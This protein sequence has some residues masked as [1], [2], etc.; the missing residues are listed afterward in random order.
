MTAPTSA[1]HV[2]DRREYLH[3]PLLG[4]VEL[5]AA[6]YRRHVFPRHVQDQ[7]VIGLVEAGNIRF[8]GGGLN[9]DIGEGDLLFIA[10]GTVH[11]A[12]GDGDSAW[13]YRAIYLTPE[14]WSASCARLGAAAPTDAAVVHDA[15]LYTRAWRAH[16]ELVSGTLAEG[17]FEDVVRAL[18]AAMVGRQDQSVAASVSRDVES[19]LARVRRALDAAPTRR[20]SISE[21]ASLSGLGRFHFLHEFSRVYGVSP[22]AY[23]LNRRLLE[24]QRR[25]AAGA[26]ISLTALDVGFA[27]QAHL[28]RHFLRTIGVTPGEY[29]KAYATTSR[30]MRGVGRAGAA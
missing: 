13:G 5:L 20:M 21:M 3:T 23:S 14:L 22:Y 15:R 11:E 28:T 10:P 19:G 9:V 24:A 17:K 6:E 26:P 29:Q 18:M 30:G 7:G 16:R 1:P 2:R 4:G 12:Y 27:D 8:T 25:L